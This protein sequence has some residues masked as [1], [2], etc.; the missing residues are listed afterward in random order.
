MDSIT[1][2]VLGAA[3]GE[4]FLG[5]K[6]GNRALFWGA[7][8]GTIPDFDVFSRLFTTHSVYGLLYHRGI[9]HSILFTVLAPFLLAWLAQQYYTKDWHKRK[10]IQWFWALTL[11]LLYAFIPL[12]LGGLAWGT[13]SPW[14]WSATALALAG[15][16]GLIRYWRQNIRLAPMDATEAP[17]YRAWW[18]MFF[19]GILTHWLIDACTAY[20]T[21][22]FEPFS[23]YPIAFNNISI[24]DPLYTGPFLIFLG[25][26]LWV[27]DPR[28]RFWLNVGGALGLSSLYMAFTFYAK[29]QANSAVERSLAEQGI[30][31][32]DYITYP[33]IGNT[34]LWQATV[35]AEDAYYYGYYSLLDSKPQM[36]FLKLPKQHELLEP[37][38]EKDF[39]QILIW[40]ARGY[41]NVLE[42]PDGSLQFNNLRFGLMGEV[43][44]PE[45]VASAYVFKH[46]LGERNGQFDAWQARDID[47]LNMR[48][49]LA[50]LWTRIK[51]R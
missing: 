47:S 51:G 42:R 43:K 19:F 24:V 25:I 16:F 34:I 37:V 46:I 3:V 39:T 49:S 38:K 1:Q 2:A 31:Y 32:Q 20:G 21:Q 36:D 48:R 7:L 23:A 22:I 26:I 33:S 5:K 27:R 11:G 30:V 13:G 50:E 28:K 14:A 45:K 18:G 15:G 6:L 17:S 35:Q 9:T 44:E 41:Y 29:S 10:G 8:A 40:F 12:G 4:L